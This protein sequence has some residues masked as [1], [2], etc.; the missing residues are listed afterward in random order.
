[1]AGPD[2]I[3]QLPGEGRSHSAGDLIQS[4][5]TFALECLADRQQGTALD[6]AD[7]LYG[8]LIL[9]TQEFEFLH[10]HIPGQ[11]CFDDFKITLVEVFLDDTRPSPPCPNW[12]PDLEARVQQ[13]AELIDRLTYNPRGGR[14]MQIKIRLR[15]GIFGMI[16]PLLRVPQAILRCIGSIPGHPRFALSCRDCDIG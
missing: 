5:D 3:S 6:L 10:S 12:Y 11:A 8:N 7:A 9:A 2:K 14:M 4:I 1:M 13:V 16:A 15:S